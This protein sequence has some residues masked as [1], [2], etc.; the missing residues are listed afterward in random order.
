MNQ[1]SSFPYELSENAEYE[2]VLY[3]ANYGDY[4]RFR[5]CVVVSCDYNEEMSGE[6]III[7][8]GWF[9]Q[10]DFDLQPNK[11]YVIKLSFKNGDF[12]EYTFNTKLN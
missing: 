10:I 12:V 7:E 9:G 11:I 4:D 5:K 8:K 6:E 2:F 3:T 1:N